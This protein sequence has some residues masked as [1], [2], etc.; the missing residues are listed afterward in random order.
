MSRSVLHIGAHRTGTTSLQRFL[1]DNTDVLSAANIS[2]LCPP[3]SR[4]NQYS[5]GIAKK[6]QSL[7]ES[8]SARLVVSE[9]NLLG[10]MEHNIATNTLYP[11]A[12][13][14]LRKVEAVFQPDVVILTIRTLVQW[15]SSAIVFGVSRSA[16]P[17]PSKLCI[18][19][20]CKSERSWLDVV[21]DVQTV[22]PQAQLVVRE[23]SHMSDNPKRFLKLATGWPEWDNTKLNRRVHNRGLG[24]EEVVSLL[25]DR[26]EFDALKRL[27]ENGNGAIFST[28]QQ[29][30]LNAKFERDLLEIRNLLGNSFL[31]D[32]KNQSSRAAIKKSLSVRKKVFLHI[33]KTGGT[34]LKSIAK[35]SCCEQN[36][37]HLGSHGETLINSVKNFGQ[38]RKLAFFFRHPEERFQSGFMSRMRQ[39]RPTYDVNWTAAE[40]VSFSFFKTPNELAE[41]LYSEDDQRFSAA[42]FAFSSIFHLKHNYKFFLHSADAIQYE[43]DVKNIIMCC[44]TDKID[45]NLGKIFATLE[46]EEGSICDANKNS[47]SVNQADTLSDLARKNLKTF[48]PEEYEIYQT[49]LTVAEEQGWA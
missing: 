42:R 35:A 39:G 23:F 14:A 30:N 41:A 7:S 10:T 15:W 29:A 6:T 36:D 44:E 1:I 21:K 32:S 13:S 11:N 12:I 24:S 9:E 34:F 5:H 17:F 31:E 33:G 40:A 18:S 8:S 28:S 16:L 20:I 19:E 2:V 27:F 38:N 25:L 48:W 45:Q 37:L 49:C 43:S 22:F 4:E 46:L 47:S 26:G 3:D